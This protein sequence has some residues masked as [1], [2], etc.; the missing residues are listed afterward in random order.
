MFSVVS[1]ALAKSTKN[2]YPDL[3]IKIT[4]NGYQWT[5]SGNAT[6]LAGAQ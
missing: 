5:P 4:I 2:A 6:A 3:D 1:L